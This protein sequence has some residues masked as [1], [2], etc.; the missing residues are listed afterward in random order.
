MQ[1]ST[2]FNTQQAH[3]KTKRNKKERRKLRNEEMKEIRVHA[4]GLPATRQK[5]QFLGFADYESSL[6][7][8]AAV[9]FS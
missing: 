1:N 6:F 7:T 5:W 9:V 8:A 2:R 3:K 4:R